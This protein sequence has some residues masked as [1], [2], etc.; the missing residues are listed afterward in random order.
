MLVFIRLIGDIET[1]FPSRGYYCQGAPWL[2][3][4]IYHVSTVSQ[5]NSNSVISRF[6]GNVFISKMDTLQSE[7][8]T[9]LEIIDSDQERSIILKRNA[10][11]KKQLMQKSVYYRSSTSPVSFHSIDGCASSSKATCDSYLTY[12]QEPLAPLEMDVSG[13]ASMLWFSDA[14]QGTQRMSDSDSDLEGTMHGDGFCNAMAA[15]ASTGLTMP[16]RPITLDQLPMDLLIHI[17]SFVPT[18]HN[19]MTLFQV[20]KRFAS[21]SI[22]PSLWTKLSFCGFEQVKD[23]N[24]ES[25]VKYSGRVKR[26]Q[27]LNFSCCH[28]LSA[29]A[30]MIIPKLSFST[31]ASLDLS[32]CMAVTDE[33]IQILAQCT[34][35]KQVSF[36]GCT[37]LSHEGLTSFFRDH[38]RL[39]EVNISH[40]FKI[41]SCT[42]QALALSGATLTTLR[43]A[44]CNVY[45]TDLIHLGNHCPKLSVIDFSF[46]HRVSD[47][48]LLALSEGCENITELKYVCTSMHVVYSFIYLFFGF[49]QGWFFVV[50]VVIE[51]I[52]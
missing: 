13:P 30:L 24:I 41:R 15:K 22:K 43:A 27:A 1:R 2:Y 8:N 39:K 23:A 38:V 37:K 16:Q 45:D 9:M 6:F 47:F 29:N 17:F 25:L 19:L 28:S 26:L 35:L 48:G 44:N 31:L 52:F 46:C 42:F 50:D 5:Y 7:D 20:C 12:R 40:C 49:C 33:S 10:L 21:A 51:L 18:L 3:D 14:T 32:N 11:W 36:A 34:E 4:F